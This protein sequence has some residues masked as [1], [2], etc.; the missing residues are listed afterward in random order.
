MY[1]FIL[2]SSTMYD[3][4]GTVRFL[5]LCVEYYLLR[6]FFE[7]HTYEIPQ[8]QLLDYSTSHPFLPP[9]KQDLSFQQLSLPLPETFQCSECKQILPLLRYFYRR[10]RQSFS[11][12]CRE[13]Q[14]RSESVVMDIEGILSIWKHILQFDAQLYRNESILQTHFSENLWNYTYPDVDCGT[15]LYQEDQSQTG[16]TTYDV[17]LFS[18]PQSLSS[19]FNG[20]IH[21]FQVRIGVGKLF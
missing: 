3:T 13:C 5:S 14:S 2:S 21:L 10:S 19:I 17:L 11:T 9:L 20:I 8:I 6:Y 4:N 16:I 18:H 1:G 12:I 15:L 7:H